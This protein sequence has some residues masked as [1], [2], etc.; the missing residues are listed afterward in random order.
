[1]TRTPITHSNIQVG[2]VVVRVLNHDDSVDGFFPLRITS[3]DPVGVTVRSNDCNGND[4]EWTFAGL[5]IATDTE[6]AAYT[7]RQASDSTWLRQ[8][9]ERGNKIL[10]EAI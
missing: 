6:R 3:V 5:F 7:A 9:A 1:M 4:V 10:T 2:D 8:A